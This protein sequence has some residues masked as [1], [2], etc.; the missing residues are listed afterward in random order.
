M[1]ANDMP[2]QTLIN[3][4][5]H[6]SPSLLQRYY[7]PVVCCIVKPGSIHAI[8]VSSVMVALTMNSSLTALHVK[9]IADPVSMKNALSIIATM[10]TVIMTI[11]M[12]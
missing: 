8:A 9:P 2:I 10:A 6:G 4:F 3:V 11:P 12:L 5:G 1:S 7:P